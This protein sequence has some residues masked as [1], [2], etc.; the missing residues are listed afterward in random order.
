MSEIVDYLKTILTKRINKVSLVDEYV[1][2]L[3]FENKVFLYFST[4]PLLVGLCLSEGNIKDKKEI[5]LLKETLFLNVIQRI[6]KV[7]NEPIIKIHFSDYNEKKLVFEGIKKASNLLLLDQDDRVLWALRTFKG[8]FRQGN[9]LEKWFLP[10]HKDNI[11]E[12]IKILSFDELY[13]YLLDK[14]KKNEIKRLKKRI[15][16]LKRKQQKM[17][18][19]LK[20]AKEMIEGEKI[21]QSILTLKGLHERG[22]DFV[23]II[24][25]SVY[26]YREITV[27][28]KSELTLYENAQLFF[29]MARKG[30][31]REKVLPERIKMTEEEILKI[32]K[33]IDL[34]EKKNDLNSFIQEERLEDKKEE[35]RIKKGYK[36]V[37]EL[38]FPLGY[39]GYAGK[40]DEGNEIVTFIIGNGEDFW[41]H[42]AD[43]KGCHLIVRNPKKLNELPFEVE[44]E[45][46]K[47]V[48]K[49]SQAP[50]DSF[51]EVVETKVKYLSRVKG[52]K[53]AVYISKFK[54]KRIDLNENE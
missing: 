44:K 1:V 40:N 36:N 21:G 49:N 20:E 30:K 17:V 54:K 10:P 27:N 8:E 25:Y 42:V 41:F 6:E 15:E 48:A 14:C 9:P 4:H 32:E 28:I 51:C 46:L 33:E 35:K 53:G 18:E 13:L 16:S 31:E 34:L 29:K 38:E 2:K 26:P 5:N 45:A 39:K 22:R 23:N 3:S 52:K 24:D 12:E 7:E 11:K 37:K 19:E 43:Y 47:Y 50:K